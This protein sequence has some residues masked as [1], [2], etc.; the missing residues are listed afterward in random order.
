MVSVVKEHLLLVQYG[1]MAGLR[2][3]LPSGVTC[4]TT[5]SSQM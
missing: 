1:D 4:H 5:L 3:Q 2:N